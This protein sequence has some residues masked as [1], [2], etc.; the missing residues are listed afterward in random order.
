MP[1]LDCSVVQGSKL[2]SLL[3]IIYTNEIPYLHKFLNVNQFSQ[4][5][6]EL[7]NKKHENILGQVINNDIEHMVVNFIDDSTNLISNYSYDKLI[8]YLTVFYTLIKKFYDVNMLK[9]NSDKT[10]LLVSC[11]NTLR[12]NANK[13]KFMA[14]GYNILQKLNTK[15]LG[16]TISNNLNHDTYINILISRVNYRLVTFKLVSIY[17]NMIN[18]S[19]TN[20]H[21][22]PMTVDAPTELIY[23]DREND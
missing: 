9:I 5:A 15:I 11:K 23:L 17:M 22:V 18:A 14:D 12:N 7:T 2:S 3:Y 19:I 21:I 13:I 6:S 16:F 1:S 10:E 20:L 8:K 4:Y